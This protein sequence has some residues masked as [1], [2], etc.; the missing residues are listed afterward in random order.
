MITTN[1]KA[2][3]D[4]GPQHLC[5]VCNWTNVGCIN[6]GEFGKPRWV[7]QGCCKRAL[8]ERDQLRIDLADAILHWKQYSDAYDT[9]EAACNENIKKI[10]ELMKTHTIVPVSS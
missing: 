1:D 4:N 6:L 2:H 9:A 5:S 7:C 8:E 10:A 3:R